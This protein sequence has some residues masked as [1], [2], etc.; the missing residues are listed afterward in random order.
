[1]ADWHVYAK[2]PLCGKT[3]TVPEAD[4]EEGIA[5]LCK[6]CESAVNAE[7]AIRQEEE[8]GAINSGLRYY[9]ELV[10]MVGE[11]K[12]KKLVVLDSI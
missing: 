5:Y 1:M 8:A 3:H 12:A 11:E 6:P 9:K 2:C 4:F 7:E 10:G